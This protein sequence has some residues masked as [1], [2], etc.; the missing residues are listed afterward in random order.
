MARLTGNL[1][2]TAGV[3]T[4]GAAVAIFPTSVC[5]TQS[6]SVCSATAT[7]TTNSSGIWD[8]L[9]LAANTYDVRI[10]CGSSVRWRRYNDEV[11]HATFQ[12]GDAC[13]SGTE[14]N[15]YWGDAN[16]VGMRWSTADSSNHA[17]VTGLGA[18]NA[19]WHIAN[20]GDI[21]TDWAVGAEADPQVFI[22][23]N[24]SPA[25]D[26]LRIGNH[27]GTVADIDVVGG[28]TLQLQ[29]A[30]NTEVSVTASGLTLPANSDLLFTGTTGT[31]DIN[32]VDSVADALSIVRG[33]TDVIVFN[34]STPLVTITPATTITGLV[35]ATGGINIGTVAAAGTDTDK[36][37]VLDG[38]GNVD[39]RTGTQVLCDIGGGSGGM[40]SFQLEDDDGT[41]VTISDA[42][43][44]KIIGSGVT[45]NWTDT[46]NGTD[47]DP[48]DL[49]ITVDA[50]Q[51]GITSVYNASLKVGRDAGNLID[52][53]TTDNK[54]IFRVECVNEVE[55]VQN[56]LSPVTSDGVAL[57]T[58]SLMWSDLFLASAGVVNFNNGDV[59][60]T[61][62]SNTLTMT[63]G[64]LTV[65]VDDT[66]HDVKF[67]GA[68]AG[69]Y[70][71]YD[72][73]A[74]QLEI[75]GA[76]AD[77]TTSTGKLLLTTALTNINAND[78]IGSINFQAPCEAGGTDAT[79]VAA[80]IRAVAQATFTCAVNATDLIFY[81]G[82]SEAAAERFRFT[83]Q[84]EIGIAGANYGTD[85]Q[86][87][88]S[89]GAGAAVAWED[90]SGGGVPNA[91]FFA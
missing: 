65:G 34:T 28:T 40:T 49:T 62:S 41:E 39:Y 45:T 72:E 53:A 13:A 52:F 15:F 12:T 1:A 74:D 21:A 48:Y 68:S 14:G 67:F 60:L 66:G 91:F 16:D 61:H 87:L 19:A 8:E 58:G 29:I 3:A 54:L 59:V 6:T 77:A 46:D 64:A 78:V 32:L 76:S 37:L 36:F 63:G 73:S 89:G 27:T 31:N 18:T 24:T 22:H 55:L 5:A 71:L 20:M 86:V 35:T 81:T 17:F 47:G 25:S 79:T 88:T 26:Y 43:E 83:S 4:C 10:T 90:A 33:S 30:G 44:V 38:S 51:T 7:T 2:S 70:L 80:G 75:R 56:A 57:G 84:N 42:K 69:A 50:A 9:A 23:S 82:H 85:G 11:Q